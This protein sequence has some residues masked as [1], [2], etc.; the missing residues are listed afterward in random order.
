[1][2]LCY[3]TKILLIKSSSLHESTFFFPLHNFSHFRICLPFK[4][5]ESHNYKMYI[6]Y[7]Y[8]FRHKKRETMTTWTHL[9]LFFKRNF[10]C[11][12]FWQNIIITFICDIFLKQ[13]ICCYHI[14]L[15]MC[16]WSRV[17]SPFVDFLLNLLNKT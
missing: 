12:K 7:L 13:S 15:K 1:M 9:W 5:K 17:T 4:N 10:Y 11:K 16:I 6:Y 8:K 14:T 3:V 2:L